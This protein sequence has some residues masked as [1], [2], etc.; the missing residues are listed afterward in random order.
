MLRL[1]LP[2]PSLPPETTFFP[3]TLTCD[4]IDSTVDDY[5]PRFDPLPFHHFRLTSCNHQDV[6]FTYLGKDGSDFRN[7]TVTHKKKN[8]EAER[9]PLSFTRHS[10][11]SAILCRPHKVSDSSLYTVLI[12]THVKTSPFTRYFTEWGT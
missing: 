7:L 9:T 2:F 5:R 3:A 1:H 11:S 8:V 6:T 12:P 4:V 10:S